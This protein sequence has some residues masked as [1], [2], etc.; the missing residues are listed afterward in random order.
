MMEHSRTGEDFDEAPGL[1]PPGCEPGAELDEVLVG[2]EASGGEGGDTIGQ[3]LLVL[4]DQVSCSRPHPCCRRRVCVSERV[5]LCA[6]ASRPAGGA[7]MPVSP[8]CCR[9][10]KHLREEKKKI[11][12]NYTSERTM[13]KKYYNMVED[14]K[15]RASACVLAVSAC[16]RLRLYHPH[17]RTPAFPSRSR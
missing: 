7:V 1:L 3:Q 15:G 8:V 14:M 4:Q 5:C 13:R 16:V 12:E 2:G 17:I 9:Q 11:V 10:L 6:C